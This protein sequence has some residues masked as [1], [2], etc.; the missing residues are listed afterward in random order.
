M[1]ARIPWY[2]RLVGIP[3]AA[4]GFLEAGVILVPGIGPWWSLIPPVFGGVACVA[5]GLGILAG[6]RRAWPLAVV[7]TA[8]VLVA[9][10]LSFERVPELD[11]SAGPYDLSSLAVLTLPA[12]A[13]LAALFQPATR[14]WAR[15]PSAL[16]ARAHVERVG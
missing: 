3:L 7:A 16:A 13:G 5:G 12:I 6:R 4:F 11:G 14:A 2:S 1:R 15:G 8:Y 10:L 9:G